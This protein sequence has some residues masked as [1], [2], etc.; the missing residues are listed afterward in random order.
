[1]RG[2][3]CMAGCYLVN[4]C[5]ECRYV[6]AFAFQF[7]IVFSAWMDLAINTVYIHHISYTPI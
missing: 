5:S 2:D 4:T 1:M 3:A 6:C 7:G